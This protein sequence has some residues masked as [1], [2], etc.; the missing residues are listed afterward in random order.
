[1]AR[2]KGQAPGAKTPVEVTR[3][4]EIAARPLEDLRREIDRLFDDFFSFSDYPWTPLSRRLF[5]LRPFEEL[6]TH[7]GRLAPRL[8]FA[9]TDK[10]YVLSAELPGM[11][12]GDIEVTVSEGVL[13]LKGEKKEA[14]EEKKKSYYLSERR[15]GALRRSI[16][17]PEGVDQDKIA[18]TFDKGVLT[19]TLPKLPAKRKPVKKIAVAKK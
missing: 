7:Y 17:L 2:K 1:M 6:A 14:K 4:G 19:I 5:G 3:R 11:G 10:D 16:S 13:T 8:D 15:Y 12:E 9:E 18:A